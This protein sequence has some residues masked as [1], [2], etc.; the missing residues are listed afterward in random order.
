MVICCSKIV[1]SN[2]AYNSIVSETYDKIKTETG[3]ILLGKIIADVWYVIEVID[4]GPNSIFTVTYFEYDTP[5][6]NHLA[7]AISKQY[8]TELAVLG[9]WHRHPG[10]MDTFSSTDDGTNTEFSKMHSKGAISGLINI[11]PNL[12][13]T[14]YHVSLPLLYKKISFE[15]GDTLIPDY[16]FSFKYSEAKSSF[17]TRSEQNSFTSR[18]KVD[19]KKT[20]KGILNK[21][22]KSIFKKP[23]TSVSIDNYT[24]NENNIPETKKLDEDYLIDLYAIEEIHLENDLKIKY[25]SIVQ[26]GKIVYS[27]NE[28]IDGRIIGLPILFNVNLDV[29]SPMFRYDEKEIKFSEGVFS[30]YVESKLKNTEFIG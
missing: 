5:Y 13:L 16:L 12:R 3:G 6:V 21:F 7:K 25:E 18:V 15:V 22:I 9:L 14:M 20:K 4:P 8:K 23:A 26:E 17:F 27:V 19:E 11:D 30:R 28:F 29:A 10:S 24:S 2:R 1:F